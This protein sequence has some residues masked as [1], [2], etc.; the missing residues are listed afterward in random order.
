VPKRRAQIT[1]ETAGEMYGDVIDRVTA[2]AEKQGA[3][4][5]QTLP[6]PEEP[7][8]PFLVKATVY[9]TVE[10]VL[11]IDKI[12]SD[13]FRTTGKKP[14]RSTVVSRAI[15]LLLAQHDADQVGEKR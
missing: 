2:Q 12:C 4:P 8:R 14:R 6:E 3:L 1:R 11:A 13:E 15:Q 9:L 10:D 5:A 7:E